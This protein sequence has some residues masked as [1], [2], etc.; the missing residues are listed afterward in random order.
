[1]LH[2]NNH[3]SCNII[4]YELEKCNAEKIKKYLQFFGMSCKIISLHNGAEVLFPAHFSF[5]L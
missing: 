4:T 1:M 3:C 5:L 2:K